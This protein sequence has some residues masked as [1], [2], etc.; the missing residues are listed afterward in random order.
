MLRHIATATLT[1]AAMALA[2][3]LTGNPF[4][5]VFCF[6]AL[7]AIVVAF[8][9]S[10]VSDGG[11]REVSS[12]RMFANMRLLSTVAMEL[13]ALMMFCHVVL[14]FA[15]LPLWWRYAMMAGWILVL[16]GA[17]AV[18]AQYVAQRWRGQFLFEFVIGAAVWVVGDIFMLR[19]TSLWGNLIWSMVWVSG[20]VLIYFSVT[21][22]SAD[23]EAVGHVADEPLDIEALRRSNRRLGRRATLVSLAVAMLVMLLWT[24]GG[25]ELLS[26]PELPRVLHI[27]MMQLP[28]VFMIAAFIYAV[29]QPLDARNREKLMRYIESQTTNEHIRASL[30]HQLVRGHRV[31]FWSRMLCWVAMPFLRHKVIG[32]EYLRKEDY[33]SVFVCNHGFIY[34]PIAAALFLPTYYRPWIHDR[35]LREDLA[36]REIAMSFIRAKKFLGK[37]LFNTLTGFA[38]R[39]T[40]KLLLSFRPIPVVRGASRDTRSTFDKSLVALTEGDNLLIFAEKGL[41][42]AK[43]DN[44]DSLRNLYTGFAH[45]GKLYHD[46]TGQV[47]LFYPVF[48]NRRQR[49]IR[50]GP[51]V[52]YNPELS[53]RDAKQAVADELHQR[54]EALS[55]QS[56]S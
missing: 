5:G 7:Y 18:Y 20:V 40:T 39:L 38:A 41:N 56:N 32:K 34:G 9:D 6:T 49:E 17:G 30:R 27:V 26:R 15:D 42:M 44:P 21:G 23:F 29:K 24:F 47:L 11:F 53:S 10:N 48:A 19:A 3:G 22:F 13:S 51:P 33:P 16:Y 14:T 43:G 36:Q 25:R 28:I 46:A 50:I 4:L 52:A 31:S 12:Y 55:Q 37:R 2:E 45:L 8:A 54:I 1:L 35:M